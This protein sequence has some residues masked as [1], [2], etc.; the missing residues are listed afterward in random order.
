ME[1]GFEITE[2]DKIRASLF[3]RFN[4][5]RSTLECVS[6]CVT[7]RF[8]TAVQFAKSTSMCATY[9]SSKSKLTIEAGDIESAFMLIKYCEFRQNL[10]K[11]KP[12]Y[13]A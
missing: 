13:G 12:I 2:K 11:T 8:C 6:L 10:Q 3:K 5:I 1:C 4:G 9:H 7:D